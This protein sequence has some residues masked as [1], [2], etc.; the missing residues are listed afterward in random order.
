[1]LHG[2]LWGNNESG[3]GPAKDSRTKDSGHCVVRE[4]KRA[5]VQTT[6]AVLFE[7][8]FNTPR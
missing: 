7:T 1:M 5:D 2:R 4:Q 8:D 3:A 6:I